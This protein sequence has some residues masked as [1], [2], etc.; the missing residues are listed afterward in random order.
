MKKID[1]LVGSEG[2]IG[3]EIK[4]SIQNSVDKLFCIDI[5]D[6]CTSFCSD[7]YQLDVSIS[8][9][10]RGIMQFIEEN[11]S[12]LEDVTLINC[13]GLIESKTFMSIS[14]DCNDLQTDFNTDID[15]ICSSLRANTALPLSLSIQFGNLLASLR[16]KGNVINFS[17]VASHGNIGQLSYSAS[18][19]AVEIGTKVLAKEFGPIG[20]RFNCL[21]PG[22]L[23]TK[24]MYD[25]TDIT[26]LGAIENSIALRRLGDI[27]S[28]VKGVSFIKDCKFI[29]GETIRVDGMHT[30]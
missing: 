6:A 9:L 20:I 21:A 4:K 15:Y 22:Y 11:D 16:L 5:Q 1:I 23:K 8:G 24:T 25:N 2:Q 17:S 13:F 29:N 7:F 12:T 3:R 26:K 28:I 14:S 30:L 18:K 19:A 27:E 10:P